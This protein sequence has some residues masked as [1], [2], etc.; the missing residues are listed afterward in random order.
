MKKKIVV[1]GLMQENYT[2][3]A[4]IRR[5]E[6]DCR[7]KPRYGAGSISVIE[8]DAGNPPPRPVVVHAHG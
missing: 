4:A 7:F 8:L 5:Q 2:Y 1:N 3:W 6:C